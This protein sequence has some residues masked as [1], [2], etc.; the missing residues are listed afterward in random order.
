MPLDKT[1]EGEGEPIDE[2]GPEW[3]R[4]EQE[5][6]YWKDLALSYGAKLKALAPLSH[7]TFA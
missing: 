1:P 5:R 6:D 3:Q 2:G 7:T 4:V